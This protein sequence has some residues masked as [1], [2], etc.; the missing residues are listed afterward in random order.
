MMPERER[1]LVL[2]RR[3]LAAQPRTLRAVGT[4]VHIAVDREDVP[5]A[6]RKTVVAQARHGACVGAEVTEVRLRSGAFVFVVPGHRVGPASVPPPERIVVVAELLRS[7]V[8]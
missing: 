8:H 1:A 6:E 5:G 4:D 7:A 2:V 3:D